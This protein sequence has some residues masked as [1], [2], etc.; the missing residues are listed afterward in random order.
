MSHAQEFD[1]VG[2]EIAKRERALRGSGFFREDDEDGEAA[3]TDEENF[4]KVK[5][6]AGAVFLAEFREVGLERDVLVLRDTG[7]Q[8]PRDK[9]VV[10]KSGF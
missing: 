10:A 4:G 3:R 6:H 2:G 8:H 7:A 9:D 1:Q 5:D